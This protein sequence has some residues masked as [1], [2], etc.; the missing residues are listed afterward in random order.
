M[1]SS[2]QNIWNEED[3]DTD[4]TGTIDEDVANEKSRIVNIMNGVDPDDKSVVVV[5]VYG[6]S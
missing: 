1:N 6:K 3:Q 4:Y 5:Q 2:R